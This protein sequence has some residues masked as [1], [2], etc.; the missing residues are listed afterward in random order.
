MKA[1]SATARLLLLAVAGAA[2]VWGV[3]SWLG[4]SAADYAHLGQAHNAV[5]IDG[6]MVRVP[7]P[8]G[9]AERLLPPVPVTTSGAHNFMFDDG[10]APVRYDPCR[11][12]AWVLNPSGMPDAAEPLVHSAVD[13]VQQA[14][15]LQFEFQGTTTEPASF[16][17]ALIQER[18]GDGFAPIVI[19]FTTA[20]ADPQLEGSVTG[21]GGSSSV[22]AAYGDEQFLHSGVVVLDADDIGAILGTPHGDALAQA[23]IQHELAHV[24]GLAHVDD[25]TELMNESNTIVTDWGPGDL[26]ALAIAGDGPCEG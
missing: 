19:G 9:P 1:L 5:S 13:A 15:G 25:E 3:S 26:A 14:T 16:D 4:L 18:Y 11:P 2:L 17:R 12:L 21:I 10:P 22:Y 23:V 20:D 7:R 6:Q 8:Q 24:V